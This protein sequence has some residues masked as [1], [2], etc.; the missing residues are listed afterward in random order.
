MDAAGSFVVAWGGWGDGSSAAV[1]AQRYDASGVPQGSRFRVN[2][3]TTGGQSGPSVASDAAGNFVVAW[4]SGQ[5][6]SYSGVFAQRY[7]ASGAPRGAE[8]QVN[9]YT[10]NRQLY[11]WVASDAV[12]NLA[13]VWESS[14]WP[15]APGQDGSG[16]GV[17]AQR[18]GGL[19]PALLWVDPYPSGAS[20]GNGVLEGGEYVAVRPWWRN[21]NG[22]TQTFN[23]TGLSFDGPAAAGVNYVLV[24]ATGT[25]G[26][27]PNGATFLCGDCYAVGLLFGG[28]RP[29][30]HW[31][32]TF[33]ER[34]TPDALGQTKPWSI[35]VGE[36]FTDV[37]RTSGY[38]RFVETLLHKGVTG[39][40]SAASYC[41]ANPVTREEMSVFV[42]AGKEGSG[43]LP[44][45]CG[46]PVF[47][48][49]PA[50]SPFCRFIEELARRGVVSGCGGGNYC[51][52]DAVTREQMSVFLLH[53]LDPSLSPPA[54][55]AP[56]F[57]DVPASSAF[58]A[59]IEELAR[60]GITG[61]CGGGNYCPTDPVTREQMAVFL[62]ATFGLS[63]YGP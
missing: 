55:G 12:G 36:S 34:L 41:P 1:F 25:Y 17:F 21:V 62:T 46:T 2:S 10:T 7:D 13:V 19:V 23:G 3:Y 49:V 60:R 24:D 57:G 61:G 35:H 44:T 15:Q 26:T 42:L 22:A 29:K 30:T 54:C 33:T 38:Y 5:D 18:F 39:G 31:D 59:W 52:T 6:G 9:T 4:N 45:A 28:T 51:P 47:G 63:L 32:A 48:D 50:S 14:P 43:Y 8:F 56:M 53:T 58:C 27:A 20:D 16:S 11:P 40:C 37:P